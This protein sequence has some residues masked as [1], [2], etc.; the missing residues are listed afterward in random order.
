VVAAGTAGGYG[1]M[2]RLRHAGGTVTR[3]AHLA[4]FA[5][6]LRPGKRVRQGEV[7]GRV[8]SSGLSTGP[9]LHYEVALRGRPVDPATSGSETAAQLTGRDLAAFQAARRGLQTWL[10]R[11]E[12]MQ[13]VAAAD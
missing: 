6:G 11:L 5:P 13:E 2:V 1:R 8:G 10:A 12:P 3:Y 4:G 9:H 7:I